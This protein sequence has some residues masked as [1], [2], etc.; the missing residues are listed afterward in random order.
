MS[1]LEYV[2]GLTP[3]T[4]HRL[5]LSGLDMLLGDVANTDKASNELKKWLKMNGAI[6]NIQTIER[7]IHIT[8]I[9]RFKDRESFL[10]AIHRQLN[11]ADYLEVEVLTQKGKT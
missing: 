5:E 8:D 3:N 4:K 6:L 11:V 10:D 7:P 9:S 1:I 2:K